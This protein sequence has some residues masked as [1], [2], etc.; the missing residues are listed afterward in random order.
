MSASA[1]RF[2]L[3]GVTHAGFFSFVGVPEWL[4]WD[5]DDDDDE[6]KQYCSAACVPD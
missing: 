5:D 3:D 6:A 4:R 2:P 1:T